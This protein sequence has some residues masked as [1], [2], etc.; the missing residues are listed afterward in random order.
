MDYEFL[1]IGEKM[2]WLIK[3]TSRIIFDQ[4]NK[5]EPSRSLAKSVSPRTPPSR[6]VQSH[7]PFGL[8]VRTEWCM[9]KLRERF[10][11]VKSP[12]D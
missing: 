11:I 2:S 6:S 10:S 4:Q 3:I 7:V 5:A 8:V 1:E 9:A 12:Q